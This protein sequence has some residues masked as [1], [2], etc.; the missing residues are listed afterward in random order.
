MVAGIES[1]M[2]V[3]FCS[4]PHAVDPMP[5]VPENLLDPLWLIPKIN[6]IETAKGGNSAAQQVAS[7]R[8]QE[9]PE[10]LDH[11]VEGADSQ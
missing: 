10:T 3:T 6:E 1:S 2:V 5:E 9:V 8:H 7:S 4:Q 11:F